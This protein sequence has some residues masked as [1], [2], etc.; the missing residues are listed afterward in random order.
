MTSSSIQAKAAILFAALVCTLFLSLVSILSPV[1]VYSGYHVN[2][3]VKNLDLFSDEFRIQASNVMAAILS[4]ENVFDLLF[5]V[6]LGF[7]KYFFTIIALG[8]IISIQAV[9]SAFIFSAHRK[10]KSAPRNHHQ[11]SFV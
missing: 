5:N 7:D 8:S 11:D 1:L 3:S 6:F 9:L 10:E 2:S 4:E